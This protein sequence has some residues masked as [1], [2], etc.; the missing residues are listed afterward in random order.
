MNETGLIT[1]AIR[2]VGLR[3]K[4]KVTGFEG[5]VA[6]ICFDL[7]G[8]VQAI[9]APQVDKDGKRRESEWFDIKRLEPGERV[10][11]VP[12][13]EGTKFGNEN[14]PAERPIKSNSDGRNYVGPESYGFPTG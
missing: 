4:D 14:G 12:N 7:Y 6:S 11:P 9:V 1:Q 2:M 13:F 8:C 5:V 3:V 10:M